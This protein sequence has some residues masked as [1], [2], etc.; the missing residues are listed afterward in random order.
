MR[1]IICLALLLFATPALAQP[2]PC[3]APRTD[4]LA[5]D[6]YKPSDLAIVRNYGGTVLAQA[7]LSALLALDPYVPTHGELLRQLGRAIPW[8]AVPGYVWYPPV[9]KRSECEPAPET[10]NAMAGMAVTTSA[11]ALTSL[12][13]VLTA[14]PRRT[15]SPAPIARR[16]ASERIQGITIQFDGRTWVNAGPAVPFSDTQFV[17]VG[18]RAGAPVFRRAGGENNVVYIRTT[19]G[20]V[21]PFRA[22]R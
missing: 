15:P 12:D 21:A 6:P 4:V 13:Q 7:P 5:F 17:R 9:P 20:M 2:S 8:W 14:L 1:P 22:S 3:T 11:G 16:S 10:P 18:E 19:P